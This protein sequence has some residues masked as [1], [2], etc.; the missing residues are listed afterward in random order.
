MPLR[1]KVAQGL[2]ESYEHARTWVS[3]GWSLQQVCIG[4]PQTL[5][6][7]NAES[8]KEHLA[9]ALANFQLGQQDLFA[10]VSDHEGA[11][12]E[13]NGFLLPCSLWL[14][15]VKGR[16]STASKCC[17]SS[18]GYPPLRS[19]VRASRERPSA[20]PSRRQAGR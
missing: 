1:H 14:C 5:P 3:D 4:A 2:I 7:R 16:Q 6:P 8:Y 12:A 18:K 19:H 20:G 15:S 17:L 10:G 9:A 13:N 11:V